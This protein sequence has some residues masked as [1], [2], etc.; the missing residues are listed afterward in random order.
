MATNPNSI[1]QLL[2][3]RSSALVVLDLQTKLVPAIF[4]PERVI[5]NCQMLLKLAEVLKMPV[6]LTSH[7]TK[8][9]GSIIPEIRQATPGIEPLEKT[10]F[11]CFGEPGFLPHLKDRAP[12]ANSL[13]VAGVESHICVMQTVLGALASG[14][15][16]HV[17]ADATSSR[18]RENW[19]IG[20]DR[21]QRAGA[22]ISSTEMMVYELL[23]VSGTP[24]FKAI[25]PLLK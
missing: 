8:G 24:E 19:Q 10:S 22:V 17:A 3:H 21:M 5:R 6:V 13:L 18:T 4:E 20:L 15:L 14:Y 23:R 7:Y 12:L 9:L 1:S 16:V 2:D 25:L 11:G